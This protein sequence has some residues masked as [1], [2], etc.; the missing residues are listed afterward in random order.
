MNGNTFRRRAA[1][2][3]AM[4]IAGLCSTSI[5]AATVRS[6]D[7]DEMAKWY[8]NAG[9]LVGSD[10]VS[11]PAT[12]A[13]SAPTVGVSYSDALAGFTNMP[14]SQAKVGPVTDSTTAPASSEHAFVEHWYGQA[15]GL[16]GSDIVSGQSE[17]TQG[18]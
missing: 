9:G 15:G 2:V 6:G 11:K 8:G 12:P 13:G 4:I 17:W 14:R 10:A 3:A 18:Q 7:P 5:G 16:T 1:V